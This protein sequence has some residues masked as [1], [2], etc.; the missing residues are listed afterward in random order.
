MRSLMCLN[1]LAVLVLASAASLASAQFAPSI[2]A[3]PDSPLP[4]PQT[5]PELLP[6]AVVPPPAVLPVRPLTVSEFV[7]TFKPLPG[8]YEVLLIHPKTGC[9]VKVCFA[10]PPGCI[11]NVRFTGHKIV[12]D[13]KCQCNVVIR[14][15]HGGK[16]WVR[17]C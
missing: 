8:K 7:A 15:L 12:F 10:L 11:R 14:F 2:P 4:A 16:V 3:P 17:G 6:P 9:P 13:Y 1:V 5:V